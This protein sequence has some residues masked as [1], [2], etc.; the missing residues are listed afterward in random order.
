MNAMRMRPISAAEKCDCARRELALRLRVYPGRVKDRKMK[1]STAEW[2]IAVMT[3][4]VED[5]C[6]DAD[7]ERRQEQLL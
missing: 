2:E 1:A 7:Q 5:Y 3:A 4:I 6:R